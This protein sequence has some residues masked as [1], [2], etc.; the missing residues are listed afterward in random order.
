[1]G[2]KKNHALFL[3]FMLHL[4]LQ[5]NTGS[6]RFTVAKNT[7]SGLTSD[8]GGDGLRQP[9]FV[10]PEHRPTSYRCKQTQRV[11]P[12]STTVFGN[13]FLILVYGYL[14]FFAARL[15]YDGS[16]ILVG[17]QSPGLTGGVFLPLISSLPDA[18]IILGKLDLS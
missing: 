4:L 15:L 11:L 5:V 10:V 6:C 2:K 8:I 13:V 18:V 12:C 14:M 3:L 17:V 7:S 9:A 1:M 16:E